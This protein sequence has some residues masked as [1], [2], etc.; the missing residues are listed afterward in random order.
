MRVA[1]KVIHYAQP[2]LQIDRAIYDSVPCDPDKWWE[3]C[4]AL[5]SELRELYAPIESEDE[6]LSYALAATG[7]Q[8]RNFTTDLPRHA[9]PAPGEVDYFV[10]E[11]EDTHV[12]KSQEGYRVRLYDYTWCGCGHHET[13]AMD[14]LVT[15]SGVI[16]TTKGAP[17]YQLRPSACFD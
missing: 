3:P 10:N 12:T 17:V 7:Y 6:A 1:P 4:T 13:Y 16:S 8:A 14:V 9:Y 11:L 15:A 2:S 5:E